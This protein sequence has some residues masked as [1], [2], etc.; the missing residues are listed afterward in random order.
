MSRLDNLKWFV[1]YPA[2]AFILVTAGIGIYFVN[3]E[4]H[5]PAK[6]FESPLRSGNRVFLLTGQWRTRIGLRNSTNSA[7]R[8]TEL[9]VDLWAFDARTAAPLWRQRL[10][11]E[12]NGAMMNRELL[13]AHGGIVWVSTPAGPIA[14]SMNDGTIRANTETIEARNPELKGLIPRERQYYRFDA[15]GLLVTTADARAWRFD[16]QS[17]AARPGEAATATATPQDGVV[18]PWYWTPN[19]TAGFVSRSLDIPGYWLGVLNEKEAA[20]F[21]RTNTI[22]GIDLQSRRRLYGA[23]AS[24]ATNFF[25]KYLKYQ[26]FKPLGRDYLAPGLL[27]GARVGV[28][29]R[30]IWLRNPDS[31][32]ILHR[33]RLGEEGTLRLARV[34]GPDGRVVWDSL[35]P[36]SVLQCVLPGEGS[37]VLLGIEFTPPKDNQPRDPFHTAQERLIAIDLETGKIN[38]HDA[39]DVSSHI[40][41]KPE[42]EP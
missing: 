21:A 34:A 24:E 22:G 35:L 18:F 6:L 11:T 7:L 17:F 41:A 39:S 27:G 32:L 40:G 36:L 12:R 26:D 28:P 3:R 30:A 16:P 37:V 19:S 20:D 31:V 13:G 2:L 4:D 10:Q 23:R 1:Y 29:S 42:N 9:F 33:D 15:H 25:G 14:A 8:T 5:S 38:V